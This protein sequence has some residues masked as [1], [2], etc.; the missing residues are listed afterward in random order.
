MEAETAIEDLAGLDLPQAAARSVL[1][2]LHQ[3]A[4]RTRE[5]RTWALARSAIRD[6]EAA[7]GV[8]PTYSWIERARTEAVVAALAGKQRQRSG[9]AQWLVRRLFG[10]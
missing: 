4:E 6:A 7:A 1:L 9:P 2:A 8:G 3:L 5:E 10:S